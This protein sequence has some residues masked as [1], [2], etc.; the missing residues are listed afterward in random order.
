MK[1]RKIVFFTLFLLL[2]GLFVCLGLLMRLTLVSS[3]NL[4]QGIIN[5]RTEIFTQNYQEWQTC[6][7]FWEKIL[8]RNKYFLQLEQFTELLPDLAGVN[9][10][11]VYFVLLQNNMELRPTGGFMGSYAKIKLKDGGMA[12]LVVQDI[13]VPDGQIVGHVD[14]PKPIQIAFKQGWFRLR[15]ANWDPDFPTSAQTIAWFFEKGKEEKADGMIAINLNLVR[16]LFGVTG[17]IDLID[18]KLKVD[19]KNYYQVAQEHAE[20]DFFAGSTQ[21]ANIMSALVKAMVAKFKNVGSKGLLPLAKIIY[22]NLQ[23][24][25]ILIYMAKPKIADFF[26]KIN[27]DGSMKKVTFSSSGLN[28]YFYLVESNLGANKANLY[29]QRK[30]EQ[31]IILT[32]SDKFSIHKRTKIVYKNTSKYSTPIKPDFWGGDY[33]NFLRVYLPAS[34]QEITVNID[35]EKVEEKDLFFE[36]KKDLNLIG[37]GFFVKILAETEREVT[38][39]YRQALNFSVDTISYSLIVQRQPGIEILP[40]KLS[41]FR[42]EKEIFVSDKQLRRDAEIKAEF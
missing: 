18:Y 16:E 10:P 32:N 40:Y 42:N 1:I 25:Q 34:A 3:K 22:K 21:K 12:D 17:P 28:D 11:K 13:Y 39:D 41:V 7:F 38:I 30:A 15:D 5:N 27:W 26:K 36:S 19:Q 31:E 2:L 6:L 35:G 20:T 33:I 37:V 9:G 4:F 29:V 24:R 14:P 8:S 23:E